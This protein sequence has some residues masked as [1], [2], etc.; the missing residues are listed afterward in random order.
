MRENID[1][2]VALLN[3]GSLRSDIAAGPVTLEDAF[4]SLPYDINCVFPLLKNPT[5]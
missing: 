4:K 5:H 2:E 3:G 1:A